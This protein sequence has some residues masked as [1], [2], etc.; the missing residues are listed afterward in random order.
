[1]ADAAGQP[2]RQH[3]RRRTSLAIGLCVVVLEIQG[4][5]LRTTV[6]HD[7]RLA[8]EQQGIGQRHQI[9]GERFEHVL[10]FDQCE[11][12]V[13]LRPEHIEVERAGNE[14]VAHLQHRQQHAGQAL[15][16]WRTRRFEHDVARGLK[17]IG[18]RGL[19]PQQLAHQRGRH[20]AH[21]ARVVPGQE[22][23][24]L[25]AHQRGK[26]QHH[27]GNH[28]NPVASVERQVGQRGVK[29]V[30]PGADAEVPCALDSLFHAGGRGRGH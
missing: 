5:Q 3:R 17:L 16:S 27:I 24:R 8:A 30:Q 7:G 1:M 18:Q 9:V 20:C 22:L 6:D 28:L 25:R 11:G 2:A 12:V 14:L 13:C 29:H 19:L 23:S 10:H 15:P 4:G 26:R 21:V